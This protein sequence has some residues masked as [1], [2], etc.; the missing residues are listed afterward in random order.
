VAR[1]FSLDIP[2]SGL[3]DLFSTQEQREADSLEKVKIVPF[4]LIDD[5]P[6]HPFK[7]RIDDEM[8]KMIESV[9]EQGVLV[10]ALLRPKP[11]G[12][13]ELVSGHRR[14]F[15]GQ[16]VDLPGLPAVI[17]E[18]DD[19]TATIIMVDSNLQ[20]EKVLASEKAFAYRMK[21]EAVRRQAGRPP[22]ENVCQVGT[23]L[24]G[25]RTDVVLAEKA[26]D[27][28]RQIQRYIRLT[29][30]IPPIL[31]MV[32]DERIKFNPAVEISHMS[33]EK[34]QLLYEVMDAD[35]CT[36][37]HAQAIK[38]KQLEQ[39]GN[40]SGET[41]IA[42]MA[43]EKGNQVEQFKIPKESITRFFAP[44]TKKEEIQAT[45][46]KAL[47]LYTRQRDLDVHRDGFSERER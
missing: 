44:S 46:V 41:I 30:L 13:Y 18:M 19:E 42:I 23:N 37:S 17:R 20:R 36:P 34:Q 22:K 32:D 43:E 16:A 10:P 29:E 27:S 2:T 14:K 21:M 25:Q 28:A 40:L 7:V 3:D 47:E 15:A 39:E 26:E 1:E 31:S 35:L 5:F 24:I 38:M 8:K 4:D 33:S 9:K 45:I 12:R 6:G 11:D